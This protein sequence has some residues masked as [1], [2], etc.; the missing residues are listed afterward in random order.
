MPWRPS[1]PASARTR[2][3]AGLTAAD[4]AGTS[5]EQAAAGGPAR[6][7]GA[8]APCG[9][10]V[11]DR[12]GLRALVGD[13][14]P[15]RR[16]GRPTTS[17]AIAHRCSAPATRKPT[18]QCARKLHRGG[19]TG[20]AELAAPEAG[21]SRQAP[22]RH[23]GGRP[24]ADDGAGRRRART[25]AP[26]HRSIERI[27]RS[28]DSHRRPLLFGL[29]FL[30]L[31]AGTAQIL[32]GEPHR[33]G[34]LR[35][36][37]RP[38]DPRPEAA[39]RRMRHLSRRRSGGEPVPGIEPR[40]HRNP[41]SAGGR[42]VPGRPDDD[43]RDSGRGA[44]GSAA[45]GPVGRRGGALRDRDPAG[46]RT[47]PGPGPGPGRPPLRAAAQAGLPPAQERLA[48]MHEK[49]IGVARDLKQAASGTSGRPRAAISAPCTTSRPFS[50]PASNGKPDYAAALRWYSEAAEAGFRDSQ[51]NIGR[52]PRPRHRH[53]ARTCPRPSSGS[54]WPPPRATRKRPGSA[55]R[56]PRGSAPADLRPPKPRSIAGARGPS[57]RS[58]TSRRPPAPDGR[59]PWID[60]Q[61]TGVESRQ[62][63]SS[64]VQTMTVTSPA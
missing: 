48:M 34:R 45:G 49:G 59:P 13:A 28:L 30:I 12:G 16:P 14:S 8:Q 32:S 61:A 24:H 51:F 29:A 58:R 19:A 27:R 43:R 40:R 23:A 63:P 2:L 52:P 7:G 21:Q 25:A 38:Q 53:A 54:P 36:G 57:T 62:A 37:E 22:A 33:L 64:S 11:P 47:R 55:T 10:P 18:R 56:S 31:A 50:P 5:A 60:H 46:R 26:L 4:P 3:A 6:S 41:G 39:S 42:Q 17:R 35:L 1:Y 20:R 44:G 9:R 15:T